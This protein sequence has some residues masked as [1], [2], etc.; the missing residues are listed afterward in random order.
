MRAER[1]ATGSVGG[2]LAT[3]VMTGWMVARDLTG[4][5]GEQAPKKLVRR[6]ARRAGLPAR[7][8]G[9]GTVLASGVAH[10][11]FGVGAGALYAAAVP[12]STIP[13]GVA[14]GLAVWGV[15][16][17]GW[18]PAIGILPPAHRDEP[19]RAWTMLTAHVIYGAVLGQILA[20]RAED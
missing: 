3:V 19:R 8:R 10:L 11:G 2:A 5:H 13:R 12:R 20:D 14:F 7:R 6:L 15:S 9:P 1:I 16:Y 18:I 17:L 4:P